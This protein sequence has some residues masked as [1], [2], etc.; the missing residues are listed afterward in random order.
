MNKREAKKE[1]LVQIGY[2]GT[3]KEK[4]KNAIKDIRDNYKDKDVRVVL[5]SEKSGTSFNHCNIYYVYGNDVCEALMVMEKFES[6]KE[7]MNS[8]LNSV[9]IEYDTKIKEQEEKIQEIVNEYNTAKELVEKSS[10]K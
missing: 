4:A 5:V 10:K 2:V 9:K 8:Y 6:K 7:Q 1:G 3:D